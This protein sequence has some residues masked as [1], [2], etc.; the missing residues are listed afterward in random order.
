MDRARRFGA[1]GI[2][3]TL[4]WSFSHGRVWGSPTF[5]DTVGFKAMARF[6]SEAL[7]HRRW[8]AGFL[9]AGLPDL[10]MPNMGEDGE[11]GP[12]FFGAYAEWMRTSPPSWEGL[13]WLRAEWDGPFMLNGVIR[14][15]DALRAVDAGVSALSVSNHGGNNLDGTPAPIRA[16]PAI[17][18]AVGDQIDV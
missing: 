11:T 16:L 12:R 7:A 6:A 9:N 2:I 14:V 13:A 18:A 17:A 8:L 5:P 1:V 3:V 15:D 4:D 10:S